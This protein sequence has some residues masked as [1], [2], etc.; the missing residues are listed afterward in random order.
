M[1]QTTEAACLLQSGSMYP[2]RL[3]LRTRSGDDIFAGVKPGGVSIYFGDSPIYHF[4]LDG[5]WQRAFVEGTHFLKGLD[6]TVRSIDRE[7][8]LGALVLRRETL[9]QDIA[10]DLDDSIRSVALGLIDEL[11]SGRL[12]ILETPAKARTFAPDEFRSFLDRVAAWDSAAWFAHRER[13]LATYGPLPFL[14]PDCP[15]ALILQA[16]LGQAE[17]R[18]FGEGRSAEH[19]VR[20]SAEFLNHAR[21]VAG[22]TGRRIKQH[23]G[24]FLGGIDVLRRPLADVLDYLQTIGKVFPI[25]EEP[26]VAGD[27]W[28]DFPGKLGLV[29][30]FLDD[31][32]L[33]LPD[34]EGWRKLRAAHL[35]QVTLGIESGD[36]AIRSGF[37][38]DWREEDVR[39][40]VADLKAA[41]IG[42]GMVV[43]V[44]AGGRAMADRHVDATAT[45]LGSLPLER[46]DLVSLVDVRTFE[47]QAE[48]EPLSDEE[49]A[50][51][52]AALKGRLARG[53]KVVAYNPLKR[54]A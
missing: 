54:W 17:G 19:H 48:L 42:V 41:G 35:G 27:D 44:G 9:P 32:T 20:T 23:R 50:A 11:T 10:A 49:S 33:S 8:E 25:G 51:Q 37:G 28:D 12:E 24:L 40:T 21:D 31:F 18:V 39:K 7:R 6:A 38:K 3:G 36:R 43:L 52:V 13:Y 22:L 45:L 1:S 16:T 4:D 30:A 53:P 46:G 5:R 2:R 29:H 47:D 15:N 14:P 26:A 34:L